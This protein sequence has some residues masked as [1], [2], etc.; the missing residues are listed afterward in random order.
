MAELAGTI[1]SYNGSKG[2][3][4]I[5]GAGEYADVM[6]SRNEL[7][8]DAR[9]VR[10]QVVEGRQVTFDAVINPDGR[11]K[12]TRVQL[13]AAEGQKLP[14]KI[15]S[16]SS[17]NGYGFV[18][19]SC[20]P[21]EQDVYFQATDFPGVPAGANL[22]GQLVLFET[23][24]TPDGKL[25]AGRIQFQTKK[26]A[27]QFVGGGA[28]PQIAA[29]LASTVGSGTMLPGVV[30]SFSER[31]GYG[32]IQVP[33]L[34]CD[35]MF[36]QANVQGPPV[37]AGAN[38]QFVLTQSP[39]QRLQASHVFAAGG[40]VD[41]GAKRPGGLPGS[42]PQ[43]K[44]HKTASAPVETRS[45]GQMLQGTVKSYNASKGWGL[46]ASPAVPAGGNGVAG[47][48]FFMKSNL[49]QEARDADTKGM[50]VYFELMQTPDG[51]FRA[52]NITMG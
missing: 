26:I 44:Q 47:D 50:S 42:M 22:Q 23:Q 16:Y 32:F 8:E 29:G 3:G 34:P 5:T 13:H 17:Q 43:L 25:K 37:A 24:C 19:S 48:V 40:G 18:T 49:P 7:P 4:F 39:D 36:K 1:R 51:K 41:F 38:V 10:G 9:E 35:I 28:S 15:K 27:E 21:D 46:I 20:L 2:F 11:A 14:G 33:G 30:K 45:T 6:F 52:Q 12:A 31:H